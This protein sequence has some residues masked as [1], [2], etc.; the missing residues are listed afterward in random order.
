LTIEHAIVRTKPKPW[1]SIDLRPW[2]QASTRDGPIGELWF[3]RPA[4]AAPKT[5]LLL[6]LLFT[7]E[8]LSIQVHPDD[9][10]ARSIGLS[11]GKTEAWYIL[12]AVPGAQV[13]LGLNYPRSATELRTA[14]SDGSIVNIVHWHTVHKGDVIFVPAGT[15]H[16]IGAGIVLAEIQQHSDATFRMYDYGRGRQLHIENAVAVAK[17]SSSE[18]Q[19]PSERLNGARMALTVNPYFA[20]EQIDLVPGSVWMLDAPKETWLL[21]IEGRAQLGSMRLSLGDAVFLEADHAE[22]E[23]GADGL[24]ALLAY[25][26]PNVN[27]DVLRERSAAGAGRVRHASTCA[28]LVPTSLANTAPKQSGKPTW[29][30]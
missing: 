13:A 17:V 14:I 1:G 4:L 24:K 18:R 20:L 27:P 21:A 30:L 6:K 15:I 11:N 10:F 2:S 16:A 22:I 5:A 25:S 12:S 3:E 8:P 26:G 29:Q 7:T 19:S 9:V 28:P 23:V